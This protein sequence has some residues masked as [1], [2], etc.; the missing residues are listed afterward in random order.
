[1]LCRRQS[2]SLAS[3]SVTVGFAR[4]VRRIEPPVT[5]MRDTS[6]ME[7]SRPPSVR[8]SIRCWNPSRIP[9]TSQPEFRASIVAAEITE[10]IPGAGPPPHRIPSFTMLECFQQP[11][12]LARRRPDRAF[13]RTGHARVRLLPRLDAGID[14]R[15]AGKDASVPVKRP[16]VLV[17]VALAV[18]AQGAAADSIHH[19]LRHAKNE[20]ASAVVMLQRVQGDLSRTSAEL[21]TAQRLVDAA[22]VRLVDARTRE[23]DVAIQYALAR[24]VLVRRVRFAYEQGP[25]TTLDMFFSAASA[26]D[27]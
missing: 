20:Q 13:R 4:D 26:S 23:R 16:L 7:R 5:W 24:D 25:V 18:L 11:S 19:R 15:R 10:L 12:V 6:V 8:P 21:A 22:T 3:G 14:Q 17:V 9:T 1:Q 27:L 2:G